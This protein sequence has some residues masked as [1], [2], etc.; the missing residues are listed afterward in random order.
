MKPML[1]PIESVLLVDDSSTQRHAITT[2]CEELGVQDV[3]HASDGAEALMLLS[4]PEFAPSLMIVD[5]EMPIMDGVEMMQQL[6]QRGLRIPIIV[7]SGHDGPLVRAVEG[8]ARNLGLPVIAGLCKPL[9]RE[10]LSRALDCRDRAERLTP[11][12]P[13]QHLPDVDVAALA[14]A[15][16]AGEIVPHYQPKVDIQRGLLRGVE[17]LARWTDARSGPVPADRFIAAAEHNGLIFTLSLSVIDQAV[18]Q[19]ASWNA[20]G[21][22]LVLAVNVS[23]CLLSEPHVVEAISGLLEKHG[24]SP[25]Q[26][27]LE[28][29]ESS[30]VSPDGPALG[31]LARFRLRGFGLSIDDYGTGL[32]SMQQLARIPF[33]ELKVDRSFV[34]CAHEQENLRVIL[35][36]A[37]TMAHRLRLV[38]V[39]EGVETVEDWR[40]LQQ[41]GCQIGQGYLLA[42]PMPADEL[43]PWIK[44]HRKRLPLLRAPA[45]AQPP[46]HHPLKA[47]EGQ[48]EPRQ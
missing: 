18:A 7:A 19:A 6:R 39:A 1:R 29:T 31:A 14:Q 48:T 22:R 3:V 2:L 17:V 21:L 5:L 43:L 15:I 11:G 40:L 13:V 34:H 41:Y 27:V 42:R 28:I 32:S 12:S 4:N 44:A 30:V 20:R 26:I 46:R 10:A 36:S 35:E 45:L 38:T 25:S 24:V 23:P 9:T 16:S 47:Q 8:M 33:T 37:L